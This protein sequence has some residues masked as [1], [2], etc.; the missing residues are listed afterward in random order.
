M[1][2]SNTGYYYNQKASG[3][4]YKIQKIWSFAQNQCAYKDSA[5][6]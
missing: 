2:K 5:I 6:Y 3:L 1:A 4:Y